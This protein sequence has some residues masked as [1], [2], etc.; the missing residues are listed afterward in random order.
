MNIW[1]TAYKT[2]LAVIDSD[3]PDKPMP[4]GHSKVKAHIEVTLDEDGNFICAVPLNFEV[5]VVP[6]TN[7]SAGRT[8]GGAPHPLC[9]KLQYVA[10]DYDKYITGRKSYF[11]DHGKGK[12]KQKGYLSLLTQWADYSGD[13][14]LAAVKQYVE[15]RTLISDLITS[16][17]FQDT[18]DGLKWDV[19]EEPRNAYVRWVVNIPGQMENKTWDNP[20]LVESWI[21]FC[22]S[23]GE[24]K[25]M[26]FVTGEE[27]VSY[28]NHPAQLRFSGDRAKLISS[29][30][31]SGFTF[32]GLFRDSSEACLISWEASQKAH[33]LLR[34]IIER[35]G[36]RNGSQ[37]IAIWSTK[38]I[39]TPDVFA[40]THDLVGDDCFFKFEPG[41][42]VSDA[43][44]DY[45]V[46]L[47]KKILGLQ[48]C[49]ADQLKVQDIG[50]DNIAVAIFD[51]P[52]S[53]KNGRMAIMYYSETA[54]SD[55][56]VRVADY[57][58]RYAWEQ[59]TGK[60]QYYGVPSVMDITRVVCHGTLK[61]KDKDDT[62]RHWKSI[63]TK[64][65]TTIIHGTPMPLE[66]VNAVCRQAV[67]PMGKEPWEREAILRMACGLYN[68]SIEQRRYDMALD[69]TI[70][71]RGYVFGRGLALIDQ[72]ES[73]AIA[74]AG[75]GRKR[76]TNAARLMT[77]YQQRP[78]ATWQILNNKLG[79]YKDRLMRAGR[80]GSL[81]F[82][83]REMAEILS[84]F[85][86]G[87]FCSDAPLGPEF[88]L[89]YYC[90]K[91]FLWD[92]L[93]KEN[94]DEIKEIE[95][96]EEQQ[97]ENTNGAQ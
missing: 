20:V 8:N 38:H 54:D 32:R 56:F 85:S 27:A 60:W 69:R 7:A 42:T 6:T 91:Q 94:K 2:Y 82:Y 89:G 78:A 37:A 63:V 90:E 61:R 4:P 50:Q 1:E 64:L 45:A 34:W 39:D 72:I 12:N 66:I 96:I 93:R 92:H 74:T 79:S 57:H 23:H 14:M 97:E 9:D 80:Y 26:C 25:G 28:D 73:H 30:D 24:E 16:G 19:K 10:G 51:S 36:I 95:N 31:D 35:Q 3:L 47:R 44:Q 53:E 18:A 84:Q 71:S 48:Q 68:G 88:C 21:N 86:Y 81:V 29:N 43:G 59:R 49:C 76:D 87:D 15:K 41:N 11:N 62:G 33:A 70:T 46:R 67:R 17:I 40:S 65:L 58:T 5:T 83:E 22:L 52:T 13:P 75:E 55:F 77:Q